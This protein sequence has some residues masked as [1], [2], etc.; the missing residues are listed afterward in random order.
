MRRYLLLLAATLFPGLALAQTQALDLAAHRAVYELTLASARGNIAAASG[1]MAY[2]MVDACDGWA[3]RQRLR[4]DI[5]DREGRD[6]E[7][8]TDYATF[9]SKDG[10]NMRFTMRQTTETAVTSETEGT[11]TLSRTGGE[12]EVHYKVPEDATKKLAA[13]TSFPTLH[14][15][16]VIEAAR[17]GKKFLSLPLFDGTTANGG[18]DTS[19]AVFSW[20]APR[21]HRFPELAALPSGRVRIAFFEQGASTPEYEIGMRYW[22]NGVADEMNMDFGDFVLRATLVDLKLLPKSC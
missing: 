8:G 11:A 21:T 15:V 4:I 20:D 17:S 2:E 18:Q 7:M 9:E 22:A 10:L 1:K 14:T 3:V 16:A 6:L 5:T 19:V 12:G 13:G